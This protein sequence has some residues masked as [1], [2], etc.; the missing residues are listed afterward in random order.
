MQIEWLFGFE[1]RMGKEEEEEEKAPI[2]CS[3]NICVWIKASCNKT[4]YHSKRIEL[5]NFF[6]VQFQLHSQFVHVYVRWTL[7]NR[8]FAFLFLS[9]QIGGYVWHCVNV[10]A[11]FRLSYI[12]IT[13][14]ICNFG[15]RACYDETSFL[16][17]SFE[18]RR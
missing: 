14:R 18:C 16:L 8:M 4:I 15:M 12:L 7:I 1:N 10:C 2:S 3:T 9:I 13:N 5:T 11:Q 6:L 17:L